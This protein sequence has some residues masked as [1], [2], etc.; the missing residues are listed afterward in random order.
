VAYFGLDTPVDA[1]L[2]YQI[3]AFNRS[4]RYRCE[5]GE[6]DPLDSVWETQKAI[7]EVMLSKVTVSPLPTK[8]T[9]SGYSDRYNRNCY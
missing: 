6:D 1:I 5:T 4:S 2:E 8:F 3:E 9:N 7:K